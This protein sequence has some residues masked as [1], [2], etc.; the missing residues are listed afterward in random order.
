MF[1]ALLDTVDTYPGV[2]NGIFWWGNW[3]ASD[4]MWAQ[5]LEYRGFGIR[6]KLAE[7]VVRDAYEGYQP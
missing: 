3:L 1:G 4:A 2:L 5:T 6:G 7:D